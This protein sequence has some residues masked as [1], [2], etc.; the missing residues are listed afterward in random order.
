M[1]PALGE[2]LEVVLWAIS[3]SVWSARKR[4]RFAEIWKIFV[5]E[6]PQLVHPTSSLTTVWTK[7][8]VYNIIH[9]TLH[10]ITYFVDSASGTPRQCNAMQCASVVKIS[11][12]A[13]CHA[14]C[15]AA[16]FS[17]L[18]DD[19]GDLIWIPMASS[20]WLAMAYIPQTIMEQSS[21]VTPLHLIG[22]LIQC[23]RRAR[24]PYI[25][26]FSFLFCCFPSFDVDKHKW[27][28]ILKL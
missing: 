16:K 1:P 9:I 28:I 14:W 24:V 25:K 8:V 12:C 4:W 19:C 26:G 11:K 7:K 20:E 5:S 23:I 6:G 18:Y 10:Y 21:I 13:T 3:V 22:N 2:Y 27:C 17:V 15:W